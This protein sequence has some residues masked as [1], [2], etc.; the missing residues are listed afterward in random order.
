MVFRFGREKEI[1]Y[2]SILYTFVVFFFYFGMTFL[3]DMDFY[4]ASVIGE[5]VLILLPAILFVEIGLS[6]GKREFLKLNKIKFSTVIL[7]SMLVLFA[8]PL[9]GIINNLIYMLFSK[10]F[11]AVEIYS[12]P[13]PSNSRELLL[14]LIALAF[15]P[16]I[17]EEF[18][19]RGVIQNTLRRHGHIFA[20]AVTGV[21]FSLLHLDIQRFIGIW[22]LGSFIG[23]IV[24]R[25]NSLYAG[26][27]AHF[28]NNAFAVIASYVFYDSVSTGSE[29]VQRI[30]HE[31]YSL[32]MTDDI[33]EIVTS[34]ALV[35]I[36]TVIFWMLLRSFIKKTQ[37]TREIKI[38]TNLDKSAKGYLFLIPSVAFIILAYVIQSKSIISGVESFL[39]MCISFAVR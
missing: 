12:I 11:G 22:M 26:I 20:I 14:S 3:L 34:I 31:S 18:L 36:F 6:R 19:F 28:V 27:A 8:L 38:E 5:F 35:V 17:C 7:V 9:F 4:R 25:T 29:G 24:Y 21:L 37:T 16:S 39:N 30:S 15:V 23:Y 33:T 2:V 10:I 32:F 1:A 13:V